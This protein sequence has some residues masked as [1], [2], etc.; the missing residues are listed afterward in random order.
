MAHGC[1]D[2]RAGDGDRNRELFVL[3][4][5]AWVRCPRASHPKLL[6]E[7]QLLNKKKPS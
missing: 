5:S 7:A 3:S 1:D 2:L 4:P 6:A